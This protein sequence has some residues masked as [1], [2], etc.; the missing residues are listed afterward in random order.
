MNEVLKCLEEIEQKLEHCINGGL[1]LLK[2]DEIKINTI[3]QALLRQQ[4]SKKKK[5]FGLLVL[6]MRKN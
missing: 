6:N 5:K 3:K 4:E 2:D 1:V